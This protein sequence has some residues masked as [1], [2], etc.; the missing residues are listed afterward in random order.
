MTTGCPKKFVKT[1]GLEKEEY[2]MF[3][4]LG[5]GQCRLKAHIVKKHLDILDADLGS[6]R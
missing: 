4:R 1:F 2:R 3:I 5:Q 6:L